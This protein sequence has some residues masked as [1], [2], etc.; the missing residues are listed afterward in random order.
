MDGSIVFVRCRQCTPHLI[1]ASL[2][3]TESTPHADG[4]SIGSAVFAQLTAES[5]VLYNG[6]PLSSSKFPPS[7]GGSGP[8]LIGLRG[9]L[10]PPDSTNPNGISIGSAVFAGLTS[11]TDRRTHRVTD[12]HVCNNRPHLH[13]GSTAKRHNNG[14]CRTAI[15]QPVKN[16]LLP[17]PIAGVGGTHFSSPT[18]Y[19][20]H[21]VRG[22]P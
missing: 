5:P 4:I 7:C 20:G 18:I 22:G 17:L 9:S 2:S 12:K 10:G 3:P 16:E 14:G 13:I 1:R 15:P 6:L 21:D 11:V 19:R 8:H